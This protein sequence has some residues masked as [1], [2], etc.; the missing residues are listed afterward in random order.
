M[1]N[2][3][4]IFVVSALTLTMM[5]A[6]TTSNTTTTD[7]TPPS[8][9]DDNIDNG[10]TDGGMLEDG[11]YN[12]DNIE[13]KLED[14]FDMKTYQD[15]TYKAEAKDMMN[16]YKDYIEITIVDGKIATVKYD[17]KNEAGELKTADQDLKTTFENQ[18][19]TY[20]EKFMGMYEDGLVEHQDI[21]K[22]EVVDGAEDEHEVFK[23]LVDAAL[24]NAEKGEKTTIVV[25][26]MT[27]EDM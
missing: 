11:D 27:V 10:I 18:F 13:D 21:D 1:K 4:A 8:T 16:G 24:Y 25:D 23:K 3:I 5:T 17:G 15:G 20:P 12:M 19:N 2:L 26:T 6:C 9:S 7:T 22:V 14:L